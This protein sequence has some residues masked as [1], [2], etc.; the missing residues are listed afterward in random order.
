M[1]KRRLWIL[2]VITIIVMVVFDGSLAFA[3]Q[4][5]EFKDGM[6][7]KG[8]IQNKTLTV[9]TSFG[10]LTP[11]LEKIVFIS[12]GNVELKDGS[13]IAG[14]VVVDEKGLVVKTKYGTWTL[15]FKPEDIEMIMFQKQ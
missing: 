14:N 8:E 1:Q 2:S 12:E 11:P 5:I 9:E 13:R 3:E 6:V 7:I 15:H 10:K 4:T